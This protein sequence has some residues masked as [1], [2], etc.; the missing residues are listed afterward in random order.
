MDASMTHASSVIGSIWIRRALAFAA[1]VILAVCGSGCNKLKARDLLNKGVA[2]YKNA[3]YDGAI[4]DFKKAKD[5][6]PGLMNARLYLA[7]A[8][9]SQYIPGAPSE[10]NMRLGTQAIKEFKEVLSIDPNNLSAIDGI[11]SILFQMASTPYDPK[12]F[13]ESKSYHQK[14]IELKPSD[15]EP[16]YWVG[17]IDWMVAQ[18]VNMELRAEYNKNNIKKQVRDTDPMPSAVRAD[19]V[20]KSSAMVEEG[21]AAIQKALQVRPD[22]DDAMVYLNLLYRRKA[23]MVESAEERAS[24]QNQADALLDK[25]KEIKQKRAAQPQQTS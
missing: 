13:E 10:Q 4:E 8:Y 2:A 17:T 25:V 21:I 11:G 18:R 9:A 12:K 20:A 24:L 19:Y 1:F 5:L 15:P 3:Q 7:T 14:H 23:D 6:D 16:Y 22:Y